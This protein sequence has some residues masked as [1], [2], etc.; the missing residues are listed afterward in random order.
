LNSYSSGRR[1]SADVQ[2][3]IFQYLSVMVFLWLLAGFW[4]LQVH[5]PEI[6][7]EQAARNRI[8]S[9]PL[10]APRGKILDRDG[11]ILV[12]NTPSFRLRLSRAELDRE[13]LPIIA[14]GLNL[15]Y[16]KLLER[17][18]RL[19]S[20]RAPEYQAISIKEDLTPAEV[21]FVE[22]HKAEFP[23]LELIRSQRRLYPQGGLAAHLVG[24]VGEV[25]D[26]ELH[27][28]EFVIYDPGTEVG[29]AGVERRY[30]DILVGTDG[31]RQVM[32]DSR[33]RSR[34]ELGFVEAVP[35][36]SLRLTIDL[37]LQVVAE[38]AMQDRRGAVV[39]LD[40]NSGEVLA[41]VSSPNYD[42]NQFVG[43]ISSPHWRQLTTD[44][45][46]P[47]LNRAI[48]AQLAP[49]SV[50]K[51][52]ELMGALETGAISEE[53]RVFCNGGATHYGR[54]FRCH[55]RGGHGWV[56]PREALIQSCDVFFYAVGNKLGIDQ[57]A[58][59]AQRFGLGRATGID[60]P[61]EEEGVVP[62]SRWKIRLFRE[63][64]YAGETI[65]VSIGQGALTVTPIQIAYALGGLA[66]GGVWHQPRLISDEEMSRLRPNFT[67]PE[68]RQIALQPAAV[69]LVRDGMWGVVNGGGTGGRARLPGLDVCGKTGTAQRVSNRFAATQSDERYLD[70]AWFVGMAPCQAPEIV[71]TALYENGEHSYYAAPIVR[72]VIKAYFD[73]K[74]RQRWTRQPPPNASD[75]SAA[76]LQPPA[77]AGAQA[78]SP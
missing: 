32:V 16:E 64:W 57:I 74:E 58:E 62:S 46:K 23:E 60:L 11:R 44:P 50:F 66:L 6:Y 7:A 38:L 21:A 47:L 27:Q 59:H 10:P 63:R 28:A 51:P 26:A 56:G 9:L 35:G 53:M 69:Q 41:L 52:I 40:P 42:P 61:H 1:K 25:S 71:V 20:S 4:Q 19:R 45:D 30:N 70:D 77:S 13:H 22:A 14:E 33:G 34:G 43:G 49:G 67:R 12:D 24:Y 73:K 17:L 29:K 5:S 72:D 8:K 75:L 37:D 48:Q 55:K 15:P 18:E 76:A 78:Q 54:Y 65:S 3:A 31:S 2:I 68:P 36:R 39:A